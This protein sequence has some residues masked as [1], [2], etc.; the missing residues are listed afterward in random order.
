MGRAR[1]IV[2]PDETKIVMAV[3]RAGHPGPEGGWIDRPAVLRVW[4]V[5]AE[6]GEELEVGDAVG[7]RLIPCN[8]GLFAL[9]HGA[10]RTA[11]LVSIHRF[12]NPPQ[13]ICRIYRHTPSDRVSLEGDTE[14][15]RHF[16]THLCRLLLNAWF[17]LSLPSVRRLLEGS[18]LATLGADSSQGCLRLR[19]Q[20][21]LLAN[22][23]ATRASTIGLR[24]P[25][26]LSPNSFRLD[27]R[28][29]S[30]GRCK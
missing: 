14:A 30:H 11:P 15:L 5:E 4:D 9:Q 17:W 12:S 28:V 18:D 20:V 22:R 6:V 19:S 16:P 26:S 3:A 24:D 25:V 29:A 23:F 8:D 2:S 21:A 10:G 7:L 1:M 13:P 27:G